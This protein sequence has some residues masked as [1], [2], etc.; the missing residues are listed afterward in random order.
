MQHRSPA[1]A[2]ALAHPAARPVLWSA[3]TLLVAAV[4]AMVLVLVGLATQRPEPAP[5]P[6]P[7]MEFAPPAG[8][9]LAL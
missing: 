4:L 3:M 9:P 2:E 6:K 7:P 1:W 5:P 8:H